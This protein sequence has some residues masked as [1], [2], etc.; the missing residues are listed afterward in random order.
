M[1]L[2]VKLFKTASAD[3]VDLPLQNFIAKTGKP[4]IVSIGMA[5]LGEIERTVNIY[6]KAENLIVEMC[7][8]LLA[9]QIIEDFKIK[10]I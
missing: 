4:S 6:K 7:E 1:G 2:N 8:K 9:N 3:L 10:K 5:T